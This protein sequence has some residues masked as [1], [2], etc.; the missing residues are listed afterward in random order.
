MDKNLIAKT[1]ELL[2][3][4]IR[5]PFKFK[6]LRFFVDEEGDVYS[7]TGY[8]S[9]GNA[10]TF[11]SDFTLQDLLN[12]PEEITKIPV[13]DK[14]VDDDDK[15]LLLVRKSN[16]D[17]NDTEY[18]TTINGSTNQIIQ[19]IVGIINGIAEHHKE[20]HPDSDFKRIVADIMSRITM[21]LITKCR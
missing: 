1:L 5:D 3:L 8:D 15:I 10:K 2:D 19:A 17:K 7:I 12:Y 4:K 14:K 16:D 13:E 20:K 21:G 9:D 6:G 11:L 18:T